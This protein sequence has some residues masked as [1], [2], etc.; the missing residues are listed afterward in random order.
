MLPVAA[1]RGSTTTTYVPVCDRSSVNVR[2]LGPT[3]V[4]AT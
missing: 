1:A 2:P 4:C 3:S